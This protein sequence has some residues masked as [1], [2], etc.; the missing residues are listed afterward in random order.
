MF[1]LKH[2]TGHG[3]A[4]CQ[5]LRDKATAP[6]DVLDVQVIRSE[7]LNDMFGAG[8]GD[9]Q[10]RGELESRALQGERIEQFRLDQK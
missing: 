5:M 9:E 7:R 8:D 10:A 3:W 1:L 2:K 6:E 4:V